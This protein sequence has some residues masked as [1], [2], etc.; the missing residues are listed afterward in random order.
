LFISSTSLSVIA[1]KYK[2]GISE[3]TP[4]EIVAEWPIGPDTSVGEHFS[5]RVIADVVSDRGELFIPKNSRVVGV[6]RELKQ[7]GS[8]HRSGKVDI[9][10][11]KIIFPD[12]ITTITID[13]DG[14][15]IKESHILDTTLEGTAQVAV[16]AV[17]G[18]ITGFQFGGIIAA[19]SSEGTNIAIGAAAGA[20][21]SLVSFI[22][23]KGRE[24]EIFPGLPMTLAINQMEKQDYTAQELSLKKT[25]SVLA[26][27]EK[28]TG[29]SIKVKITN[30]LNKSIPLSN[31][32]IVDGLGYIIKPDIAF[33][34][35]DKKAIPAKSEETYS[36]KFN[37]NT[38]K[39]KYWLVL[40]DSFGKQE[41]FK[42]D[43]N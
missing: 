35:F 22:A 15:L 43:L 1:E 28:Y 19:G 9:D 6:V 41:Y 17:K 14:N 13:A 8:F 18:A 11:Q 33:K 42:E 5:A 2:V 21:I 16:G 40:T 12:N 25:K 29:D 27:I 36:F 10:F 3:S 39:G 26:D 7:A 32:K 30:K 34:F 37:P 23:Q 24:V 20:A 4:V 38:K 31:L